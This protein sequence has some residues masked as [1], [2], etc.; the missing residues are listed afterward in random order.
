M[1]VEI[2]LAYRVTFFNPRGGIVVVALGDFV[3]PYPFMQAS[4]YTPYW[5]HL[6]GLELFFVPCRSF[7]TS[8]FHV[9]YNLHQIPKDVEI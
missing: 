1:A 2:P 6:L 7:A 3:C 4:C 5:G 9:P 8:F